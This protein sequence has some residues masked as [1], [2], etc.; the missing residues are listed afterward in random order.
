MDEIR[1]LI[2]KIDSRL[3]SKKTQEV[4]LDITENSTKV[5]ERKNIIEEKL[6]NDIE[7]LQE[8][9]NRPEAT[10]FFIE[11]YD[12]IFFQLEFVFMKT[13]LSLDK[14]RDNALKKDEDLY[15]KLI[16]IINEK[17]AKTPC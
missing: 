11:H 16:K 17:R 7:K 5:N 4:L 12:S 10:D 13:N 1:K 14:L 8:L 6:K 3:E 2:D 9:V 15:K